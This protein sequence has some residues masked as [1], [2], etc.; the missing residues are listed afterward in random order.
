MGTKK[1]PILTNHYPTRCSL[2]GVRHPALCK[3]SS[4]GT[5]SWSPS[6]PIPTKDFGDATSTCSGSTFCECGAVCSGCC[7]EEV[8]CSLEQ[9][10]EILSGVFSFES[11]EGTISDVEL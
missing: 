11:V 5:P 10:S 3:T 4:T 8:P 2:E 6:I 1:T 7:S 9:S